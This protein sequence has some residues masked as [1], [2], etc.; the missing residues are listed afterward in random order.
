MAPLASSRLRGIDWSSRELRKIAKRCRSTIEQQTQVVLEERLKK[1]SMAADWARQNM[2]LSPAG[3]AK[4]LI[5]QVAEVIDEVLLQ[6]E[7][8]PAQVLEPVLAA[9]TDAAEVELPVLRVY[10]KLATFRPRFR[11][12]LVEE[13]VSRLSGLDVDRLKEGLV[14]LNHWANQLMDSR[15]PRIPDVVIAAVKGQLDA[16]Y[17]YGLI[18]ILDTV[19][20]LFRRLPS[21]QSRRLLDRCESSLGHWS[22]RL[23][24]KPAN[25]TGESDPH[26]RAELPDL[27]AAMTRLC[28]IAENHH[29]ASDTLSNW[30]ES[31]RDDPM[32]E[33]RRVLA[34]QEP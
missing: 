23:T 19:G 34:E 5:E 4:T 29:L 26:L 17:S 15:I 27:R 20:N 11:G 28:V 7:V 2:F 3:W 9:V 22:Q 12:K 33:I 13:I 6:R 31:V 14:A 8:V 21:A 32:P 24:Y 1:P 10:P 16:E 18:H 30:L 25:R